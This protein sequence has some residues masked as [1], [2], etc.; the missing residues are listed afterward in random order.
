MKALIIEKSTE[1]PNHLFRHLKRRY[2]SDLEIVE[3]VQAEYNKNQIVEVINSVDIVAAD[4]QLVNGSEYLLL[5]LL[6][7]FYKLDS[8]EIYLTGHRIS[9]SLES[10]L[11]QHSEDCINPYDPVLVKDPLDKFA[12][13]CFKLYHHTVIDGVEDKEMTWITYNAKIHKD[14]AERRSLYLDNLENRKTDQR[15]VVGNLSSAPNWVQC[16]AKTGDVLFMYD[17]KEI[18]PNP[19]REKSVW[20][21][22]DGKPIKLLAE[23]PYREFSFID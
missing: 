2:G 20:T 23:R 5:G 8:K 21:V 6:E 14:W 13:L 18:D 12:F 3:I 11:R 4:T 7:L 16:G 9:K 19:A 15:I 1:I 22:I 10:L 17:L